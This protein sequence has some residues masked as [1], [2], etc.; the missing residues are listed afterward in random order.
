MTEIKNLENLIRSGCC[1]LYEKSLVISED[2]YHLVC[3]Y[4]EKINYSL[5]DIK[6][7]LNR[8]PDITVLIS[9]LVFTTWIKESV[10]G[11]KRS[12]KDSLAIKFSYN[13]EKLTRNW[14]FLRAIRSFVFVHPFDTN[15]HP[16][17]EFDGTLK[18]I[19][20]RPV[21]TD[22]TSA[23]WKSKDRFYIDVNGKTAYDG[24]YIDYWLYIY[25]EKEYNCVFKQYIGISVD[26]ICE[27]ANDYV[28]YLLALDRYLSEIAVSEQEGLTRDSLK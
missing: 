10:E 15:Q 11:I 22:M 1:G 19:D 25:N 23:F 18:C 3:D 24:Q 17:F 21:G 28:D 14:H 9:I 7:V 12:Y 4:L 20:I 26:S 2:R 8:E 6:M 13:E 27:I 16:K 5:Q